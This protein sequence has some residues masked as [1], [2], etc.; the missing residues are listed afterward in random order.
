[1]ELRVRR[2]SA[3]FVALALMITLVPLAGPAGAVGT[4]DDDDGNVHESNI[5]AIAALG[6]TLGCN[7]PANTLYC[8]DDYVTR[9]QMASFLVRTFDLP[10][11]P[12]GQFTDTAGSVHENDINAL[13]ASGI[14]RG[15]NPPA[16]DQ[17]CPRD[18]V[19]RGQ[20]AAF[21]ARGLGLADVAENFFTDDNGNIFEPQIN[22]IARVGI[23]RGCNPPANTE[24]CADN[25]VRRD[26]MA[27]FLS[28]VAAIET[29]GTT[30]TT[31]PAPTT[32]IPGA[33]TTTSLPGQGRGLFFSPNSDRQP[34]TE[35]NGQT[36]SGNAY[37]FA[38]PD[39]GVNQTRFYVNDPSASGSAYRVEDFSKFDLEGTAPTGNAYPFDTFKLKNGTH[40]VTAV[41]VLS[42]GGTETHTEN[43]RVSNPASVWLAKQEESFNLPPGGS[44]ST[45]KG[46]VVDSN[47]GNPINWTA[48]E[49]ASWLTLA[50][51]SGTGGESVTFNA[52]TGTLTPGVRKATVTVSAPGYQSR[53]FIVTMNILPVGSCPSPTG[54]DIAVA[55]P[56][57][58]DFTTSSGSVAASN[59]SGT[60]FTCV[61]ATSGGQGYVASN[62]SLDLAAPGTLS[63]ATTKGIAYQNV[64]TQDNALG[65]GFNGSGTTVLTTTLNSPP[66]EG[67]GG[68]EQAGIWAGIHED[69]YVKGVLID[70]PGGN[71]IQLQSESLG[72]VLGTQQLT[73]G[74]TA[75][76][77][78]G[79]QLTIGGGTA[80]L[81]YSINGGAFQPL[82]GTVPVA[83]GIFTGVDPDGSGPSGVNTMGGI[84]ASHRNGTAKTYTFGDFSVAKP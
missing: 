42:G 54:T 8:P 58:L 57:A 33:T 45:P 26:E 60:G 30:V 46:V 40:T 4:F 59:G 53:S 31:T 15:C 20:M 43:I 19:T 48:T 55:T 3:V 25:P 63:I 28:R 32:S 75:P 24:Y 1:M 27:S 68:S 81:S 29:T 49:A 39:A 84:F 61:Q 13:A 9:Q 37:I 36:F 34:A 7:P 14:T 72:S 83:A 79:L 78:V 73:L 17:Y 76:T 65:V 5:E 10:P 12:A 38:G 35:L 11:A 16:N 2:Y 62:L 44:S 69:T 47:N 18:V 71:A 22:A 64:D 74:A 56:Y 82:A 70:L 21:M 77:T 6:I 67:N 51:S 50:K 52:S 23:T 80:S 41:M 66:W